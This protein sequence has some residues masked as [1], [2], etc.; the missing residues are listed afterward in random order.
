M[1]VNCA[2]CFLRARSVEAFRTHPRLDAAGGFDDLPEMR[3]PQTKT[4]LAYFHHGTRNRGRTVTRLYRPT[5]R[6]SVGLTWIQ[7]NPGNGGR[8][9]CFTEDGN[10]WWIVQHNAPAIYDKVF[11]SAT[12][13]RSWYFSTLWQHDNR[14]GTTWADV[15]AGG[16]RIK[17][18]FGPCPFAI[19][20]IKTS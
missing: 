11:N 2:S 4:P 16:G 13:T 10:F 3:R 7:I 5:P 1:L 19:E 12:P 17:G 9:L 6:P 8:A 20:R 15:V 18:P 14:T